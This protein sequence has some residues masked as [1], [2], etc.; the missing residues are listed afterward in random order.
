MRQLFPYKMIC[1]HLFRQLF[2]KKINW[3][4]IFLSMFLKTANNRPFDVGYSYEIQIQLSLRILWIFPSPNF[5]RIVF[6]QK[7]SSTDGRLPW[8]VVFHW[9]SSST[10]GHLPPKVVF[11]R[12]LSSTKSFIPTEGYLPTKIVFKRRASSTEGRLQPTITP[13]LILNLWEQTTYQISA[14]YLKCKM[15]DA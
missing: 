6:Y 11:H 5:N 2:Q 7:L 3:R 12:R 1:L 13:W 4:P 14:S 8:K 15:H 10:E 9:R